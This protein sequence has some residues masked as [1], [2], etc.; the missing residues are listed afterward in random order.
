[1][2]PEL[3]AARYGQAFTLILGSWL[4]NINA[5]VNPMGR[6]TLRRYFARGRKEH[7][8]EVS[9]GKASAE[10]EEEGNEEI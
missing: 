2:E 7:A 8:A 5:G 1:M 10:E 9:P 6:G 3:P 4:L